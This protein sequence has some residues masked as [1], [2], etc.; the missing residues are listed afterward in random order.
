M[1]GNGTRT[2]LVTAW[3]S[4]SLS[5]RV[6]TGLVLLAGVLLAIAGFQLV[7]AVIGPSVPAF[8]DEKARTRTPAEL[9]AAFDKYVKEIDGRSLFFVP[10]APRTDAPP[11]PTD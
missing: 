11:P 1:I 10:A 3:R 8:A 5:G 9:A 6:V 2:E 7:R 4:M